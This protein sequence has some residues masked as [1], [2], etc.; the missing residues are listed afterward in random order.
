MTRQMRVKMNARHVKELVKPCKLVLVLHV[1]LLIQ[2]RVM[3]VSV[4]VKESTVI[5]GIVGTQRQ[6]L[7]QCLHHPL[8]VALVDHLPHAW[9]Y[10]QLHLVQSTQLV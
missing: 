8:Q 3:L 6:A 9:R 10:A 2:I 7:L 5:A 1:G 4:I